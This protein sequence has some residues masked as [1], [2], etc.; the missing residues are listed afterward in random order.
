MCQVN[1]GGDNGIY[2]WDPATGAVMDS[3][4]GSPWS[5]ISQRGLAYNPADDT[6]YIGGWNEGIIYHVAG[7]SHATPGQTISQCTA[8]DPA[9]SGFAYNPTAD[10]L[11]M[12]TNSSTDTIYLVDPSDCSTVQT[13]AFP[14]SAGFSG[15]GIE[16]DSE[17]NLWLANQSNGRMYLIESGVPHSTDVPWMSV[18]PQE[19]TVEPGESVTVTVTVDGDV[20]QPGTYTGAVSIGNDTPYEVD[21][22]EVTMV[23]TPPRTWGK[24]GG[25]V[26]G[27]D[28][29]GGMSP[30]GGATVHIEGRR[31]NVTLT[32]DADGRYAY[33]MPASNSPAMLIVTA[34][35]H[36]PQTREVQFRAGQQVIADFNLQAIC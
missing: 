17:G 14:D 3:M 36:V 19:F 1:V 31:D 4:T 6:F 15:A 28:C 35:G 25:T 21:P 2:C 20:D 9:P 13:L 26:T 11:W 30:L 10:L 12:A 23:V 34:S 7:F 33:W 5:G 16:M 24:I 29:S 32:T 18:D 22:V 8:P 27:T